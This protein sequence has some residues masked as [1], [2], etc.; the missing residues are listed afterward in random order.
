MSPHLIQNRVGTDGLRG[1][2]ESIMPDFSYENH[3]GAPKRKIAGLDEVGRGP[4]AGPVVAACAMFV[5]DFD[6]AFLSTI[7]DSKKLSPARR[8]AIF[9]ILTSGDQCLFGVGAASVAEIESLN[10]GKASQLAMRRALRRLPVK[11]DLA[12]V[13]GK[14]RVDLPCDVKMIV[15]GDQL[16]LSIAAASIIAKVVR[17]RLMTKLSGRY[18]AYGWE[19]NAG[20]GTAAHLTALRSVGVCA[21]HRRGFAPVNALL[22]QSRGYVV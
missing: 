9:D 13:D 19:R 10:V 6:A 5:G 12:L 4:I 16:S 2:V 20:Y 21:H 8:Q 11:P 15:K 22:A 14:A 17:D 7:D 3:N 1:A 18:S